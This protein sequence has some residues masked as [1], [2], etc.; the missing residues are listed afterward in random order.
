MSPFGREVLE[1]LDL[2]Q[3][4]GILRRKLTGELPE[5]SSPRDEVIKALRQE[6]NEKDISVLEDALKDY[7]PDAMNHEVGWRRE[8]VEKVSRA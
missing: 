6:L 3:I 4:G 1:A 5:G 8:K 2:K 7:V